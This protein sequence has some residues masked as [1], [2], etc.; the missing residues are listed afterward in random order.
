[1]SWWARSASGGS[2]AS[3]AKQRRKSMW[4]KVLGGIGLCSF[5]AVGCSE[6]TGPL[7]PCTAGAPLVNL[8]AG[9]YRSADPRPRGDFVLRTVRGPG[10]VAFAANQSGS[11]IEYLLVP[12]AATGTPGGKSSFWL[13]GA[14][15]AASSAPAPAPIAPS[16]Q[17]APAARFHQFL[18]ES[19]QQLY[20]S[21]P[22]TFHPFTAPRV[23]LAPPA[24]GDIGT[25]SVCSNLN[26]T[27][28]T[29]V[30]ATAREVGVHIAIFV[31]D[32][33]PPGGLSAADLTSLRYKFDTL[34][35]V[36]D[37]LAFGRESDIDGNR[38]VIVLMTN[39]V[40]QLV[41]ASECTSPTGGFVGGYFYGADL[42]FGQG[43]NGE[44]FY[45]IVA[46]PLGTL[47]C[48]H[49]VAQV[50][51]LV[52][53]TFIHEFQH[54]ISFGQHYLRRAGAPEVLWLNEGLSHFAEEMG[55]RRYLP[56]TATFCDFVNGDLHNAG[57]YFSAPQDHYLLATEGIGTLAERGA[58]WL[59]VRYLVDQYAADQSLTA[60]DVV[61]R[62]LEQTSLTGAANVGHVTGRPFAETVTHWALANYVS[63]TVLPGFTAPPELRY[64]LWSFRTDYP[65][66]RLRCGSQIPASF[67]LV[68]PVGPG[69]VVNVS[70]TLRAGSGLYY[71]ALQSAG[72][73][74]F[75]LLFSDGQGFALPDA[76]V[77]R[78]NVIRIK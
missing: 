59:F 17:L 19:E 31:D 21:N 57:Q 70:D 22:P 49:S 32:N 73:A 35:Y 14:T 45:S 66:L 62:Q 50:N 74:G 1:M 78:L 76:L 29:T 12:Q 37:T 36:R 7:A 51:S 40:N 67:P 8:T 64:K 24:V 72:A 47:S 54:M 63:D 13:R 68:P 25:F 28:K 6:S 65:K 48:A 18:R 38:V 2:C 9:E 33:A 27:S 30:T 20:L 23:A 3:P 41:T 60:G 52:P 4:G 69:S 5:L 44:I 77:P 11:D 61:T 39:A 75:T 34:L 71:L 46:D 16:V 53:V 10:C 58:M 55:G 26:C 56:D 15:L 42:I 43:N